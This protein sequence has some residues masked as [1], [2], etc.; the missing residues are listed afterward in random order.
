MTAGGLRALLAAV[1]HDGVAVVSR[2]RP[3]WVT[4]VAAPVRGP[5]GAVVAALSVVA[6]SG[7]VDA[8]ALTPA[9]VAVARAVSRAVPGGLVEPAG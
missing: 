7:Q 9:V 5:H 2:P 4:S 3:E 8:A 6:P 1:R